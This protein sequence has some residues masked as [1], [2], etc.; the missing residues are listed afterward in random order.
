M[1]NFMPKVAYTLIQLGFGSLLFYYNLHLLD[2]DEFYVWTLFSFLIFSSLAFI[3]YSLAAFKDPGFVK[4]NIFKGETENS[5]V[6]MTEERI[7]NH[8]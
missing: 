7:H 2:S 4:I 8:K 5:V 1:Y 6:H 3:F